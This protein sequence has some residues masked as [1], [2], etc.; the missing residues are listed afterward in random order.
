[1]KKETFKFHVQNLSFGWCRVVMLINDKKVCYNAS[2]LGEN[3]LASLIDA[4]ADYMIEPGKY[5]LS[6]QREPGLLKIDMDLDDSNML[7]L[8][9]FDQDESGDTIYGEWHETIP[10]EDFVSAIVSEGFKVLNA[11][12]LYGYRCSWQNHEDFPL[13]NLLRITGK[14]KEIWKER[15]RK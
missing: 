1:M 14:C 12:G 13:T 2:Y 3:P 11:F 5:Y 4:C 9:I 10:F 8:D 15:W 6:W 7:H